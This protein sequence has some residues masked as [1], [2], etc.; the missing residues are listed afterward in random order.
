MSRAVQLATAAIVVLDVIAEAKTGESQD[1][2]LTEKRMM[3]TFYFDE[4]LKVKLPTNDHFK[5][6]CQEYQ[7]FNV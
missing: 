3:V 4:P 6:Q 7:P 5:C 2:E 1:H